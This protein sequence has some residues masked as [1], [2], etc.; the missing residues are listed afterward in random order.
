MAVLNVKE[1]S[2]SYQNKYQTV[3]AVNNVSVSFEQGKFYAIMGASGSGKTT[4]L[5]LLAGLD[6]PSSGEIVFDGMSIAKLDQDDYRKEHISVIYQNFNL[7]AH[8]TVLENAAYQL[9]IQGAPRIKAE[10][11]AKKQLIAVGL[12]ESHFKRFPN[13]LSGGEQQRVAIARALCA[14]SEIILADE[15]TGN[16]DKENGNNIVNILQKLAHEENRCVIV[17]TH[18]LFVAQSA[19]VLLN[20]QDGKILADSDEPLLTNKTF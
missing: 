11:S 2:Y 19:D 17:V 8:L 15:P 14:G 18:D 4:L 10:E 5:S 13:M 9:Y 20:M 6:L 12:N 3:Y 7:F 1:V 16:L